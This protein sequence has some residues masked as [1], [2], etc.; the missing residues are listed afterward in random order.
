MY[1]DLQTCRKKSNNLDSPEPKSELGQKMRKNNELTKFGFPTTFRYVD[2]IFL[3]II[4]FSEC[5]GYRKTTFSD[6]AFWNFNS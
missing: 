4:F 3:E 6:D 1:W 5:E 2:M